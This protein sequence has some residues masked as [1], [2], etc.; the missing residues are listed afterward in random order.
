MAY[1]VNY[2]ERLDG[3]YGAAVAHSPAAERATFV[4]RTYGHV[5]GAILAFVAIE[6][7]LFSSGA[8]EAVIAKMFSLPMS[9]LILMVAFMGGNYAAQVMAD[10]ARSRAM[11]YAGLGLSVLLH[12][13]IFL[14][15]L[16]LAERQFQ[17]QHLP[18]QAGI[19]TMAVFGA[20][21]ATVFISG[22]D[23]SFLG[24][25]LAV[26]SFAALGVIVASLIFPRADLLGM[27]FCGAMVALAGG[28]IVYQTSNIMHRYHSDQYVAA[29][30]GLFGSV[31]MM[32]FYILRLFIG[33]GRSND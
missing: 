12:A 24:P 2:D 17:G 1:G 20:L 29:S 13:V 8:A 19:V 3:G 18:A 23:F 32:F 26:L 6:A 9:G 22:K 7:A 31:A 14:P 5:L 4:K 10:S 11:Q 27:V 28:A 15:L 33:F 16:Y 25:I 30:L 21:T